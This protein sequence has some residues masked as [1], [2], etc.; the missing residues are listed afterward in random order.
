MWRPASDRPGPPEPPLPIGE[1]GAPFHATTRT[2]SIPGI[3]TFEDPLVRAAIG[4]VLAAG[5]V[6]RAVLLRRA[7]VGPLTKDDRSP[8][9]IADFASQAIV[10]RRLSDRTAGTAIVAEEDA[11]FL[12]QPGREAY[13]EAVLEAVRP[14][15]NGVTAGALVEALDLGG[16]DPCPKGFWT[17]DPID[18]TKGFLRGQHHAISL[19]YVEDGR[20]VIGVLLCPHLGV[21]RRTSPVTAG[22]GVLCAAVLGRGAFEWAG[23]ATEVAPQPVSWTSEGPAE[24][25]RVCASV[26]GSHSDARH[27]DAMLACLGRSSR[28]LLLDSQ[29]KYAAVARG[30]A[31]A[32]VR[33]PTS[34]GYTE[35]IWDHAAGAIIASEAG[36][37]VTD[38]RGRDLD[39]GQGRRLSANCG[40][41]CAGGSVHAELLDAVRKT[42]ILDRLRA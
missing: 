2:S 10:C 16:A 6:C 26:E 8:V 3:E 41:L 5:R 7:G 28:L 15:W 42:N 31:D 18:G 38:L 36:A 35:W 19:A 14:E 12:R 11:A 29:T 9:T 37:R 24:P 34:L 27:T 23:D 4:A 13:L 40:V 32:Y 21:D 1:E 33:V 17:L 30:Q 20:P 39:F 22:E 25:L